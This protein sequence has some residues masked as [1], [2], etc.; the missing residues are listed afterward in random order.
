[1]LSPAQ[2]RF[3]RAAF[4][5]AR[6]WW[7]EVAAP[8]GSS[9]NYSS[10]PLATSGFS[11]EAVGVRMVG[12]RQEQEVRSNGWDGNRAGPENQER[13]DTIRVL[14]SPAFCRD[15]DR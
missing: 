11:G 8:R 12:L 13:D 14:K 5:K 3:P 15:S 9:G 7:G 10:G 4:L 2:F 6:G 1:M